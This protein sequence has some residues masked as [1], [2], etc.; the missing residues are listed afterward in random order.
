[1]THFQISRFITAKP[2]SRSCTALFAGGAGVTLFCSALLA[3]NPAAARTTDETELVDGN[4]PVE[5]VHY[6]DLDL[7]TPQGRARLDAR[8]TSAVEH[9]CGTADIRDLRGHA[10][11]SDCREE[12]LQQALS[13]RDTILASRGNG[14]RMAALAVTPRPTAR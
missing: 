8:I 13:A 6:N 7:D 4:H 10:A 12:S 3:A 14:Q 5:L 9:V 11:V 2:I 1:M